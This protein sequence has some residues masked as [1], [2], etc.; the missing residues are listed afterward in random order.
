MG[1]V[2]RWKCGKQSSQYHSALHLS[3]T[4]LRW[5]LE[6]C[7]FVLTKHYN[8]F[9]E[10]HDHIPVYIFSVLWFRGAVWLYI[11]LLLDTCS[12]EVNLGTYFWILV[13]WK[14]IA[15]LMDTVCYW[16]ERFNF[17]SKWVNP[18]KTSLAISLMFFPSY[19]V[20]GNMALGNK[21]KKGHS[22]IKKRVTREY[23]TNIHKHIHGTRTSY[24]EK[25]ENSPWRRWK[26]LMCIL[27]TSSTKLSG[28][29]D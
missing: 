25:S 29:K 3:S 10:L 2:Q 23:T 6:Y 13:L 17:H 16:W 7:L 9:F 5:G 26:H 1:C 22:A 27:L 12:K 20:P 18:F 28:L 8:I 4:W 24:I 19:Q 15:P 14:G 21:E 11:M